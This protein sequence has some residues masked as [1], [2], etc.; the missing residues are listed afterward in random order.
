MIDWTRLGELRD[1][2]GPEEVAE[3]IALFLEEADEAMARLSALPPGADSRALL[4]F[5][6]GSALNLGF[7]QLAQICDRGE[8]APET[9][10]P[11]AVAECYAASRA[12]FLEGLPARLA[13]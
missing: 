2:I 8:R 6:K 4:H 7:A 5:L 3:V 1:E 11:A 12:A 9:A 13:A 10:D